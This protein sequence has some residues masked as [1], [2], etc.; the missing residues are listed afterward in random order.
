M[1]VWFLNWKKKKI[2]KVVTFYYQHVSLEFDGKIEHKTNDHT[3]TF[4]F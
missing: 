2:I 4:L 3:F 1:D